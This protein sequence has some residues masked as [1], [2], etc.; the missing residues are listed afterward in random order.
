MVF[1]R[2]SLGCLHENTDFIHFGNRFQKLSFRLL[3]NIFYVKIHN[4]L[5]L[6]F[7]F[8]DILADFT[9]AQLG[10][11]QVQELFFFFVSSSFIA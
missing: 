11:L 9:N 2:L 8:G 1:K 7:V 10:H 3:K 6:F 5:H 4:F